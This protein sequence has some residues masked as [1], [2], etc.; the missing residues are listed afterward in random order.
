M[1]E[2]SKGESL[3]NISDKF[4]DLI[5][6]SLKILQY[7]ETC[8][9]QGCENLMEYMENFKIERKDISYIQ[10]KNMELM[11]HEFDKLFKNVKSIVDITKMKEMEKKLDD[12]KKILGK[13]YIEKD[14]KKF[15]V[16][17]ET[18]NQKE[19]TRDMKLGQ[20][21]YIIANDLSTLR[22]D[23]ISNLS[24][25]LYTQKQNKGKKQK[26]T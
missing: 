4:L 5:F 11:I 24:H 13:E 6:D 15:Y 12:M 25:I 9:K 14:G 8:M 16:Y 3:K 10:L 22:G 18:H 7:Y 26:A 21:F 1:E 2:E 19:K 20:V 23:V 17:K